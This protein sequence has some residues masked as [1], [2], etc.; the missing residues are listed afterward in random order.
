M[1]EPTEGRNRS[2][3]E[4][5]RPAALQPADRVVMSISRCAV[6]AHRVRWRKDHASGCARRTAVGGRP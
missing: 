5:A 2:N 3:R 4:A 1:P 6:G